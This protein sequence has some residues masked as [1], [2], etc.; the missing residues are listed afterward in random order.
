MYAKI[1]KALA[2]GLI[3]FS[4][5]ATSF[6]NDVVET[7]KM[8][9]LPQLWQVVDGKWSVVQQKPKA[10]HQVFLQAAGPVQADIL[11][12]VKLEKMPFITVEL[13]ASED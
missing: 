13:P 8:V 9:K 1:T 11:V 12:Q 5:S 10:K 2:T 3:V 7:P 4:I 6:A